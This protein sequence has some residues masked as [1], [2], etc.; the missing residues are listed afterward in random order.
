MG[1]SS[2]AHPPSHYSYIKNS[3]TMVSA[4]V[5]KYAH[6]GVYG[7]TA[8]ISF[9]EM[10]LAAILIRSYNSDGYPTTQFKNVTRFTL[11]VSLFNLFFGAAFIYLTLFLSTSVVAS[12]ASN[13]A[14]LFLLWIFW[15]ASG[16][17]TA[18]ALGGQYSCANEAFAHCH[19]LTAMEAFAWINFIVIFLAFCG[20]AFLGFRASKKGAGFTG[21]VAV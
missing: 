19:Q 3:F 16:A 18:D 10:I 8:F 2:T 11:F 17:S 7:F 1:N 6:A 4:N 13:L 20:I 5:T 14:F 9:I 21:P 15:L 12:I